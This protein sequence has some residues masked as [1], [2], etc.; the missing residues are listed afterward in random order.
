MIN[1][2]KHP[3]LTFRKLIN[4]T[5]HFVNFSV[6][7]SSYF[8]YCFFPFFFIIV[9]LEWISL[10]ANST[11]KR[12]MVTSIMIERILIRC[13]GHLSQFFRYTTVPVMRKRFKVE[14]FFNFLSQIFVSANSSM[15]S[16]FNLLKKNSILKWYI[17][18]IF[19]C[20]LIH[21]PILPFWFIHIVYKST[22]HSYYM[23]SCK[24][25]NWK[26]CMY[27]LI[28]FFFLEYEFT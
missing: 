24:V 14:F 23:T 8:Y 4:T 21:S 17:I 18:L 19:F 2:I 6:D 11:T 28:F 7:F 3:S 16:F 5:Q 10:V 12:P 20:S 22:I 27:V 9:F 15:L 26:I 25:N 1:N 13:Y